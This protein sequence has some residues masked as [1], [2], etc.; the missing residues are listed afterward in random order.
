MDRFSKC[1]PKLATVAIWD[2]DK[3]EEVVGFCW[4]V[5]GWLGLVILLVLDI[6]GSL[7]LRHWGALVS[8]MLLGYHWVVVS[9]PRREGGC[10]VIGLVGWARRIGLWVVAPW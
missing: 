4:D 9:R 5:G 1:G 2:D 10:W 7:H 8:V 6:L 3:L